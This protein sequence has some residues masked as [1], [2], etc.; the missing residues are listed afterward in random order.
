MLRS[1]NRPIGIMP[2]S[3]SGHNSSCRVTHNLLKNTNLATLAAPQC[4]S[5][6]SRPNAGAALP[7]DRSSSLRV[8]YLATLTLPAELCPSVWLPQSA[9]ADGLRES[10]E[11]DLRVSPSRFLPPV[12]QSPN[13]QRYCHCMLRRFRLHDPSLAIR[14]YRAATTVIRPCERDRAFGLI[15]I[16]TSRSSAVKNIISRSTEKP[17]SL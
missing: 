12:R 6:T 17:P 9:S 2:T 16:S 3:G 8:F 14:T 5:Q 1:V 13:R 11:Y 15:A 4:I 7:A 10:A